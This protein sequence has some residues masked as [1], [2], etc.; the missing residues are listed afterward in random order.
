MLRY[1]PTPKF[2]FTAVVGQS[3]F[4][5]ALILAAINPSVGG[6]LVSGPR[7]CAKSTLAR[8]LTDI[9]PAVSA[10]HASAHQ[11]QVQSQPQAQKQKQKQ[12]RAFVTLPLGATED[13]LLGTLNLKKVLEEQVAEFQPGILARAD[14][15][16]LY[17]DEVNLLQDSLVDVLLDVATSGVN[18]VERDGISHSH[19][20]RFVL[21]GTM[22]P[23]EGD[24]RPQLLD[25][26]G[27]MVELSSHLSID[28][29]MQV[30][31]LRQCFDDDPHAFCREYDASQSQLKRDIVAAQQRL[32]HIQCSD[33]MRMAI[34]EKSVAS[35][36]DGLRA[37]I[38][39]YKAALA[40]A[41]WLGYDEMKEDNILA[42]E[43]LVLAHRRQAAP[44]PSSK[45]PAK[46]PSHKPSSHKQ[47]PFSRPPQAPQQEA[48]QEQ[49]APQPPEKN[50][51][52]TDANNTDEPSEA[53][54][55][56]GAMAPEQQPCENASSH[57]LLI[58]PQGAQ[59]PQHKHHIAL[60]SKTSRHRKKGGFLGTASVSKQMGTAVDWFATFVHHRGQFPLTRLLR[61]RA[62]SSQ[63]IQHIVV[64]DTSA[65]TLKN[66]LFAQ[67]KSLILT[68]AE[69]AYMAREQLT[70]FGF[71]NNNVEL[72]LANARAPKD[73][74]SFLDS[75]P[76]AGGTPLRD[77]LQTVASYQRQQS[78]KT[79]GVQ[80]RTY[81][82][83][84]GRTQQAYD[85]IAL[86]GDM[87][88]ID[89][90]PAGVKCGKARDIASTFAAQYIPL[91]A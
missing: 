21:L 11:A 38:V 34:A 88:V 35:H 4:K 37:D 71:G 51:A 9:L 50:N 28:E 15:G 41:A 69:Q 90:E 59:P 24:I 82:I 70:V 75:I 58:D 79:P 64:L 56:W 54:G 18:V 61:K 30:V 14:Q 60:G 40:H 52:S 27:L 13:M 32:P 68:L 31:K 10:D 83:T 87:V 57:T 3:S 89:I 81:L 12:T 1:M 48:P 36:V 42:V 6:V 5:L 63:H 66:R 29:R 62:K 17:V 8:A 23:E 73:I 44:P 22:N 46:P 49:E 91:F 26:F 33:D 74:R 20:S 77:A 67:A 7:G 84:D 55:D 43:E 47:P 2:P 53:E 25:R 16:V 86:N 45:P 65:S 72:L 80:T 85:D 19:A 39:W 76:A 78:K